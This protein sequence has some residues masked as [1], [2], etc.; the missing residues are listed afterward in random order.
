MAGGGGAGGAGAQEEQRE[1]LEV[2][3]IP[4][5]DEFERSVK[6][7]GLPKA[8]AKVAT[9]SERDVADL[10]QQVEA[11]PVRMA[12]PR[13]GPSWPLCNPPGSSR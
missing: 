7:L 1:R 13:R 12:G 5:I 9:M 4:A 11:W 3:G 6:G 2:T 8:K 10:R